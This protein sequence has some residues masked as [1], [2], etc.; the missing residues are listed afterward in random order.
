MHHELKPSPDVIHISTIK[1]IED[2]PRI[3]HYDKLL[4]GKLVLLVK[5]A[6]GS[7]KQDW[8]RHKPLV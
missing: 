2:A 3:N 7:E 1:V 4:L 8:S 5:G 6:S